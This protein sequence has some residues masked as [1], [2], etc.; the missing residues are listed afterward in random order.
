V[1]AETPRQLAL[2]IRLADHARLGN[3]FPAGNEAL[4]A[5][6]AAVAAGRGRAPVWVA[7]A[8]GSGR[9]HL[10]QA[11]VA[12]VPAGLGAAY[13]PLDRATALPPAVLDGLGGLAL[14]AVD[15]VDAVAGDAAFEAALFR[16]YESLVPRGGALVLAARADV[17]DCGFRLPDLASRLAAGL[18]FAI[19][20]LDDA[21]RLAAL[22]LRARFRG[23]E[24]PDETGRYL[25]NRVARGPASLFALLDP[26]DEA[27]LASGRR[28]T[29]PFVRALI[30]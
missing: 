12:A 27:A 16:L 4:L 23:L 5:A 30:G 21:G 11:T 8:A 24:L 1:G 26:L 20:P 22:Q 19:T 28:L 14:V 2:P 29:V 9:T 17:P 13:V 15:D 10:L 7:G 3:Y 6:L 25:L 18:R